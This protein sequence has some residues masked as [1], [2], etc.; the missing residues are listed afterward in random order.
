[1][2]RSVRWLAAAWAQLQALPDELYKS[3]L[4]AAASLMVDPYPRGAEPDREIPDTFV[5]RTE[6]ITLW[7]RVI[8]D[9]VDVVGIWPNS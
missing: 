9:E 4:Q 1:M 3:A 5:L 8:G 2:P 7:Y 6:W